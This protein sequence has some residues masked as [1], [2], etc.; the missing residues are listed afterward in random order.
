MKGIVNNFAVGCSAYV[1][2]HCFVVE[3]NSEGVLCQ[4]GL[5]G[6]A[7]RHDGIYGEDEPII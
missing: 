4:S 1:T 3:I 5:D 7:W 2:P 6:S